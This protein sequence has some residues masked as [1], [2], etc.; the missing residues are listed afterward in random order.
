[1]NTTY[2]INA[3]GFSSYMVSNSSVT[4]HYFIDTIS[5]TPVQ[6][7]CPHN[8]SHCLVDLKVMF[9][10]GSHSNNSL[11]IRLSNNSDTSSRP[12]PRFLLGPLLLRHF[13]NTNPPDHWEPK[14]VDAPAATVVGSVFVIFIICEI[15]LMLACDARQFK[16]QGRMGWNNLCHG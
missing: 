13:N 4:Q 3:V 6:Q 10:R 8:N 2:T 5:S 15:V 7:P 16:Q 1:M 11:K 9:G 12:S 14:P